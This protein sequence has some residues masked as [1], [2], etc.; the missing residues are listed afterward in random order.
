MAGMQ[1]TKKNVISFLVAL[2]VG[3]VLGT[4]VQTQLNLLALQAIGVGVGFDARLSATVHDLVSFAP[5][6]GILF[7]VSFVVSQVV[8]T[9]VSRFVGRGLRVPLF[10]LAGACGLWVALLTANALAPMPTLIAA[11]RSAGGLLAMLLTAAFAGALFARLTARRHTGVVGHAPTVI[12][13]CCLALGLGSLP[14][15]VQAQSPGNYTVETLISGLEHPWSLAFLPEGGA[16]VT[17]RAG[18]LRRISGEWGLDPEPITGVPTVFNDAQAGLFDVLLSPDFEADRAVFLAYACGT[19]AANHLCVARCQLQGMALHDVVEIFRAQP[20]KQGSAHYGGRMAWLPDGTLIVT[21][22]DG[23]D[24][25]EQAQDLS[26][27][28]GKIVRLNPDGTAPEDNPFVGSHDALPE[29]Y[30]YGHRNVQ[31]LV[32]DSV[33]GLLIAH[34]HGPRGGDEVN[35]I[36]PGHNYGWPGITHGIDYT[37]AMITPFVE[38]EGMEQPLLHW[39][40]SI[41]PSGMTRY[42]GELFPDWHGNL[43]VGALADRSVHRVTLDGR[44]ANDTETMFEELD[45]RIR[46]VATGPDGGVYL[47]TDSAEGRVL[48]IVP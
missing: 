33:D 30:S 29:I 28:L 38:H 5:L 8:A 24:Y 32:Y 35:I 17:E 34:E 27:H 13:A 18:R 9:A 4:V 48:R 3:V 46:D 43:L 26:S 22:G 36:E 39:T 40:P 2:V 45:E 6:Y 41:A 7:G 47:L 25:R 12:L 19:A 10:A 11:T 37:G 1:G 44:Q 20:A 14:A 16:L 31:G 42:R 21:L 15:P 23:F